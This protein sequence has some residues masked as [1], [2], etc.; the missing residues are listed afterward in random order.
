MSVRDR[1]IGSIF[2]GIG[3]GLA[4]AMTGAANNSGWT[5]FAGVAFILL[6]GLYG[7]LLKCPYCGHPIFKQKST[8]LG[9]DFWLWGGFPPA[10]CPKC[11]KEL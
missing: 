1:A 10:H 11:G 8:V 2:I 5:I 7:G 3:G 9:V 4:I 6:C